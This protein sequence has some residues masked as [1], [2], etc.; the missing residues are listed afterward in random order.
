M[1]CTRWTRRRGR[2]EKRS[3]DPALDLPRLP[4]ELRPACTAYWERL[5]ER[6]SYAE[7]I[8]GY[9]HPLIEHGIRGLKEVKAADP[10][11]RNALEGISA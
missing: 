4:G 11:L 7:A 9:P 10:A 1:T 8:L 5:K 3:E 2:G 6:S